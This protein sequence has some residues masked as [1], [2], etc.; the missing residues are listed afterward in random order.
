[1]SFKIF[2]HSLLR[3]ILFTTTLRMD[4]TAMGN[5]RVLVYYVA[6]I[7]NHGIV[8]I[9]HCRWPCG[10]LVTQRIVIVYDISL[11]LFMTYKFQ[12][13]SGKNSLQGSV[14]NKTD[15]PSIAI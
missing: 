15:K 4:N 6:L 9:I 5:P 1:M 3:S 11:L 7:D 13:R 12:S 14:G 8:R 10:S 2:I